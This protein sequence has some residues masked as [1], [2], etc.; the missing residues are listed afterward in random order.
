MCT[1]FDITIGTPEDRQEQ[2]VLDI[3]GLFVP[4]FGVI[5]AATW[6]AMFCFPDVFSLMSKLFLFAL[7][8]G[9][10]LLTYVTVFAR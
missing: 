8:T 3:S 9:Y 2:D 5:L 4:L 7:S 1:Y 10:V 6:V